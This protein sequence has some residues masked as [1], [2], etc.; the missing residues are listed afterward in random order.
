M[1]AKKA[2]DN[3][4]FIRNSAVSRTGK[5]DSLYAALMWPHLKYHDQFWIH[6]YKRDLSYL[7]ISRGVTQLMSGLDNKK[8]DVQLR[9]LGLF[10]P[11]EKSQCSLQLSGRR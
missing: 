10:I 4:A 5:V 2:D 8:Q 1:V 9:E 6:H 3:L 11:K 7:S